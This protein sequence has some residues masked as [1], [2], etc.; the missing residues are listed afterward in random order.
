MKLAVV[1]GGSTYTPELIDGFARLRDTLPIE[2]L[3]LVDELS[4]GLAPEGAGLD[5]LAPEDD[6]RQAEAP[7]DQKTVA[8]LAP[9]LVRARVGPDVEIL[10]LAAEQQVTHAAAHQIGRV[11]GVGQPVQHLERVGVDIRARDAMRGT[12]ANHGRI[13]FKE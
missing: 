6:V 2:E 12:F 5:H 8:E 9:D 4:L 7:S 10:G 3:V 1:G 11:P 13:A